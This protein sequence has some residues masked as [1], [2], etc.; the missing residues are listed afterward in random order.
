MGKTEENKKIRRKTTV[1]KTVF[2][3]NSNETNYEFIQD[4]LFVVKIIRE[5]KNEFSQH[6]YDFV[7]KKLSELNKV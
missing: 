2:I 5:A 1:Q 7:K 3:L 4:T 6:Y